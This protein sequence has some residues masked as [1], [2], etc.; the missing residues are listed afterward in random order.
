MK[1]GVR[2]PRDRRD[3]MA[4]R[5]LE[6]ADKAASHAAALAIVEVEFDVSRPTARNLISRGHYLRGAGE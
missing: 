6:I 1:H 3:G 2:I 4:R 5:A